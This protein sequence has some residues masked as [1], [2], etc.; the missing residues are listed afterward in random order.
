MSVGEIYD[1]I[2]MCI[3]SVVFRCVKKML[4]DEQQGI[5]MIPS[6]RADI[7]KVRNICDSIEQSR[8]KKISS[9]QDYCI[10][11]LFAECIICYYDINNKEDVINAYRDLQKIC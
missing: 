1:C 5:I 9:S 6:S 10:K 3:P 7:E 4:Q 2:S 8:R 11:F